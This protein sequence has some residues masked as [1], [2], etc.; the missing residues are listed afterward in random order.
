MAQGCSTDAILL[1]NGGKNRTIQSSGEM[2]KQTVC[3]SNETIICLYLKGFDKFN[4][5]FKANI[6]LRNLSE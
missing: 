4:W 2:M 1:V 3:V 5:S 6:F